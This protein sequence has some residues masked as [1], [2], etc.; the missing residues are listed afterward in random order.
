MITQEIFED[1]G[2]VK[3]TIEPDYEG[4]YTLCESADKGRFVINEYN[5]FWNY[6]EDDWRDLDDSSIDLSMIVTQEP[7]IKKTV[8]SLPYGVPCY[9]VELIDGQFGQIYA[10]SV[11]SQ[12]RV[13]KALLQNTVVIMLLD[14]ERS[15]DFRAY[16]KN[17]YSLVH[18]MSGWVMAKEYHGVY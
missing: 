6:T 12:V 10:S 1:E 11:S 5:Q 17:M 4:Q 14:E 9:F 16:A 18:F 13:G 15:K 2:L 7:I 3:L 8:V